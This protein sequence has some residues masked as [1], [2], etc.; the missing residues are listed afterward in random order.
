MSR[1]LP[2]TLVSIISLILISVVT[3]CAPTVTTTSLSGGDIDAFRS[4]LES[5]DFALKVAPFVHVDLV[6]L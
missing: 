5:S 6:K 2:V 3:S 4:S 1:L